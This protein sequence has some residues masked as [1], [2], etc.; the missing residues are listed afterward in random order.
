[1]SICKSEILN[2]LCYTKFVYGRIN[3]KL[4]SNL[5]NAEIETM[6]FKILEKTQEKKFNKIGKNCY[7]INAENKIKITINSTHI[8]L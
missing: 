7:V 5:S 4:N 8:E 1:M 3:K 6:L 2:N